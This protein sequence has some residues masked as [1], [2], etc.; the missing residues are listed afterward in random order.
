MRRIAESNAHKLLK[1]RAVKLLRDNGFIVS[2]EYCVTIQTHKFRVDVVG[3]KN[4]ESVAIECGRT[5]HFKVELLKQ[6]FTQVRRFYYTS[7]MNPRTEAKLSAEWTSKTKTSTLHKSGQTQVPKKV[8]KAL[9]LERGSQ[10]VWIQ[11]G[12]KIYVE[13]ATLT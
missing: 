8:I 11:E 13:S 10:I 1:E 2:E 3:F 4:D 6:A 5:P 7:K 12:P 9:K